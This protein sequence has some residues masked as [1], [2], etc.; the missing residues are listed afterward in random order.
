VAE[1]AREQADVES[2]RARAERDLAKRYAAEA[3]AQKKKAQE[4]RK[5]TEE[6]AARARQASKILTGM[7]DSSDPLGLNG[8]TFGVNH[9]AGQTLQ[10]S[11]LLE[12]AVKLTEDD[13]KLDPVVKAIV[14]HDVGNVYRSLGLHK[15][16]EPLLVRALDLR[17]KH[18]TSP[19]DVADSLHALAWL[20]HER[21]NYL[22][23][24][25]LYRESLDVR[26][27][28]PEPSEA[29][30]LNTMINLGWLCMEMEE[31][32]EGLKIF[33]GVLKGR[34][35][36]FGEGHRE[37]ALA[38]ISLAG[39]YLKQGRALDAYPLMKRAIEDLKKLGIDR[40]V[41]NA[42][43]QL[44]DALI[45][46]QLYGNRAE[47]IRL[48]RGA[49]T[50][51]R[52]TLGERHIYVVLPLMQL[53]IIEEGGGRHADAFGHY[54][55]AFEIG[56]EAVG[57]THPQMLLAA[58]RMAAHHRRLGQAE[59]GSALLTEILDAKK[60]QY[61]AKHVFVADSLLALAQH[62]RDSGK[63]DLARAYFEQAEAIYASSGR[64][65]RR[66]GA[67]LSEMGHHLYRQGKY[68][69]SEKAYRKAVEINRRLHKQPHRDVVVSI[70]NLLYAKAN[71]G[72]HD[73]EFES[74][75]DEAGALIG[76]LPQGQRPALH[77]DWAVLSAGM[78]TGR[79]GD[80]GKAAEALD[81]HQ[82]GAKQD[83][84]HEDL[85]RAYVG[86][87]TALGRDA[88]VQAGERA[89]LRERYVKSAVEQMR[90]WWKASPGARLRWGAA[91]WAPLREE[92]AFV[93]LCK[94]ARVTL[95]K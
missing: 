20:R 90:L 73:R 45:Q 76:S 31:S 74:R 1:R 72:A 75:L 86:C 16:A 28:D 52:Q 36:L 55:E 81:R 88:R 59:K 87:V 95:K 94:E 56:K 83:Y 69:D 13:A 15:K 18:S 7:F 9:K 10:A 12:R 63:A 5:A 42:T 79:D 23:A 37:T 2:D 43:T 8:F 39:A 40:N 54:S 46:N 84:Q 89:R 6:H 80:H 92:V 19:N 70:L 11:D 32:D 44:Q 29:A 62:E 24:E 57:V 14:Y 82:A 33:E 35:R 25:K 65:P 22:E 78:L 77:V 48:L 61:G 49:V 50:L 4:Q 66:H 58:E 38:R 53:A 30:R 71:Q 60:E 21:G 51:T 34:I 64:L 91:E 27:K 68:A 3:E 47:A 67:C 93:A 85:A 41:I 17:R 26:A